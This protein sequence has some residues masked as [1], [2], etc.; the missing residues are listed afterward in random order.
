MDGA[1]APFQLD[2]R[3]SEAERTYL[4][5]YAEEEKEIYAQF[6]GLTHCVRPPVDTL[7]G[8]LILYL[9]HL[10]RSAPTEQGRIFWQ[11][12]AFEAWM[13]MHWLIKKEWFDSYEFPDFLEGVQKA[14][15]NKKEIAKAKSTITKARKDTELLGNVFQALLH[16]CEKSATVA[17]FGKY[18][19]YVGGA[20]LFSEIVVEIAHYG[21]LANLLPLIYESE[22]HSQTSKK[23]LARNV[24]GIVA[25]IE[26]KDSNIYPSNTEL[27]AGKLLDH[28]IKRAGLNNSY[29]ETVFTNFTDALRAYIN[30]VDSTD[31]GLVTLRNSKKDGV[32]WEISRGK[33]KGFQRLPPVSPATKGL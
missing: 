18:P 16:L 21:G 14:T 2:L 26:S 19:E 13:G 31:C 15:S 24:L 8:K 6:L 10:P 30:Q 22:T 20:R 9:Q 33:S 12:S 1:I 3:D 27:F 4:Y 28:A 7:I 25:Q 32:N 11:A 29:R 23:G 5:L 17:D